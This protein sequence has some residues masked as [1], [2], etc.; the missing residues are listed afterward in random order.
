MAYL[1]D[2]SQNFTHLRSNK[3]WILEVEMD[4]VAVLSLWVLPRV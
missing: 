2:V 1:R 3:L 4:L